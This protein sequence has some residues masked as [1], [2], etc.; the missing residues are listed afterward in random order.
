MSVSFTDKKGDEFGEDYI[1]ERSQIGA[2]Y[3]PRHGVI[4]SEDAC[5][6]YERRPWIEHFE[7]DGIKPAE[8]CCIWTPP[9]SGETVS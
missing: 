9:G 1:H 3:V 2:V 8:V 6:R 7:L 5:I 4:L